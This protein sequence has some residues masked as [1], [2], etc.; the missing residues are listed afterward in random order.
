MDMMYPDARHTTPMSA[1]IQFDFGSRSPSFVPRSSSA[2]LERWTTRRVFRYSTKKSA[3]NTAAVTPMTGRL[4]LSAKPAAPPSRRKNKSC[5]SFENSPAE[6]R[7]STS[8]MSAAYTVSQSRTRPMCRFSMPRML[9]R[10]N[11]RL[12]CLT[13]TLLV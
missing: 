10:P 8:A 7:P 2:G 5:S 13:R 1:R 6:N 11:S 9:Y 12:R 4:M 3:A